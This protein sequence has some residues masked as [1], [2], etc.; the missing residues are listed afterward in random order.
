MSK[1][2]TEFVVKRIDDEINKLTKKI[3][4]NP[5]KKVVEEDIKTARE[6][7]EYLTAVKKHA[8]ESRK[9]LDELEEVT[10]I[11]CNI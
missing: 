11:T 5:S 7:I 4:R 1:Q 6:R 9:S 3:F 10:G 2:D 8:E